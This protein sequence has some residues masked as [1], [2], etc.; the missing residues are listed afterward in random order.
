MDNTKAA[1][2]CAT[3]ILKAGHHGIT[4][5]KLMKLLYLAERRSLELRAAP[6][7]YDDLARMHLGPVLLGTLGLIEYRTDS[8]EWRDLIDEP[9]CRRDMHLHRTPDPQ[10]LDHLSPFDRQVIDEVWDEHGHKTAY[11]LTDLTHELPEWED[12]HGRKPEPLPYD[13]VLRNIGMTPEAATE[14]ADEIRYFQEFDR[15]YQSAATA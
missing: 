11:E 5:L 6:M 14:V 2:V 15:A 10:E 13:T 7:I 9:R 8:S 1:H 4:K 12:P 3:F